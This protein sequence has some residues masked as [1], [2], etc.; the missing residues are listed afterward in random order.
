MYID[1]TCF[2][3]ML[4]TKAHQLSRVD[5]WVAGCCHNRRQYWEEEWS[6]AKLHR[7]GTQQL[8]FHPLVQ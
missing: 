5:L 2:L 6:L 4:L 8:R 7:R 1:M 3:G